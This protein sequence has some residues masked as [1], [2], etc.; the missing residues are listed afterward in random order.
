MISEVNAEKE[1]VDFGIEFGN[2]PFTLNTIWNS[3]SKIKETLNDM[4][5]SH[6]KGGGGRENCIYEGVKEN[7]FT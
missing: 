7:F 3:R 1:K 4:T 6:L 5:M 2:G